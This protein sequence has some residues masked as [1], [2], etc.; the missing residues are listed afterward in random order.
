MT[1]SVSP[2]FPPIRRPRRITMAVGA[3][4]L[5]VGLAAGTL[6]D[7]GSGSS[8]AGDPAPVSVE[9]GETLTGAVSGDRPLTADAAER[10]ATSEAERHREAC[11]SGPISADAAERCL[12]E[13]PRG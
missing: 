13:R 10:W 5:F 9:A 4:A 7:D 6:L 11:T 3:A 1:T 8:S 12:R 2:E